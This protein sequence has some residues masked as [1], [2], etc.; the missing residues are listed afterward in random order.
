MIRVVLQGKSMKPGL[1]LALACALVAAAPAQAEISEPHVPAEVIVQFERGTSGAER[2]A[3]RD[4]AG[5]ETAEGLGSP[6]LQ[7]VEVTDDGSV[8]RTIRELEADPAVEFA[9]PNFIDRLSAVPEDPEFP[10]LWGLL[11]AG[12]TVNGTAGTADADI[13]APEAWDIER[14]SASTVIAVMDSGIDPTHPDLGANLWENPG[15]VGSNGVDDDGNGFVDDVRGFDFTGSEDGNPFDAVGHGTHVSGTVA[16]VGGNGVGVAGVS[17]R[18]QIMSLRVCGVS[19]CP[20]ADQIQ[21]INYAAANGARVLN[22]SLGGFSNDESLARRA[23]IFSNQSVLHVFAAGNEGANADNE[24]GECSDGGTDPDPCRAYPCAHAPTGT[25]TDNVICVAA[26]AQNDARPSFSNIGPT[27]VDLG[28]PGVNVLSANAERQYFSDTFSVND[29]ATRWNP[30]GADTNWIRTNEAPLTSFGITDSP[31]A[32]YASGVNY[33]TITDPIGAGAV[34]ERGCFVRVLRDVKLNGTNDTFRVG[35]RHNGAD[36]DED[37]ITSASNTPPNTFVSRTSEFATPSAA[38]NLEIRLRL[39]SAVDAT[40]ADGIHVDRVDMECGETPG[41]HDYDFKNGTSMASP[42]V[43]GA[44]GLL[45]SRNP[46]ASTAEIRQ[47]LLSTVD[48]KASMTGVTTTGGRLNIGRGVAQMPADTSIASGPGEGEEI[49]TNTP[50][51]GFSSSDPSVTFQCSID[52]GPFSACASG[53]GVGPVAPGSH[54]LAVRSVDPRGNAD[55]TPATRSFAVESDQ[56][57]TTISKGPKKKTKKRKATFAFGSDEPGSTF[58][59]RVDKKPFVDCTSPRRLKKVK[60]GRHTFQ[61][62]A[63]D[64]AGNVDATVDQHRWRVKR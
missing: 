41:P 13:D 38:G 12:Q 59:C 45:I 20:T 34:A 2:D 11:N 37:P 46:A 15:E 42:H 4:D 28:A 10:R 44:A 21:A 25:E 14:G 52:A 54:T 51:F 22:A 23:A 64:A 8:E 19:G 7:L 18:A 49:A 48:P 6:G 39:L 27:S 55:T 32:N 56:P 29:F 5:T 36:V 40:Q 58:E 17:Q 9:E 63:I 31:A 61:V 50:S 35:L 57:E 47:K 53:A 60:P 33:G 30:N 43:A 3:V 62:R 24:P 1:W 16:G 26:T